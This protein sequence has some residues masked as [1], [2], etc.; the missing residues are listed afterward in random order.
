[1]N[2]T[3]FD[4]AVTQAT[5]DGNGQAILQALA[6]LPQEAQP[7][8]LVR[9]GFLHGGKRVSLVDLCVDLRAAAVLAHVVSQA[10]YGLK[11][12]DFSSCR[13]VEGW[14]NKEVNGSLAFASTNAGYVEGLKL[15]LKLEPECADLFRLHTHLGQYATLHYLAVHRPCGM[16]MREQLLGAMECALLL[17][18]HGAPISSHGGEATNPLVRAF[19]ARSWPKEKADL[20]PGLLKHYVQAGLVAS[21]TEALMLRR[22]SVSSI[23]TTTTTARR[24]QRAHL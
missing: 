17:H 11:L 4:L 7:R 5:M 8:D 22:T 20:L 23:P 1:M 6:S 10:P 2:G 3:E 14:S 15:A 21:I 16:N 19:F 9:G 13:P 24:A 12:D 18:S